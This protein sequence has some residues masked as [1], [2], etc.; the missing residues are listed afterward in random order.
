[1]GF[2]TT[3]RRPGTERERDL[4]QRV[5]D[6]EALIEEARR[7]ARRRRTVYAAI[8]I[9]AVAAG[10]VAEFNI[11]WSGA[12]T[13]TSAS[14]TSGALA[15]RNQPRWLPTNGPEG[16]AG[17]VAV[18]PAHPNVVYAGGGGSVFKSVDG[19]ASWH[20]LTA[21]PWTGVGAI[22]IDPSHPRVVYAGTD[23]GVAKSL[24]GGRSWRM[25]NRGLLDR[26]HRHQL[27][28]AAS[29]VVDASHPQTVYAVAAGTLFR[30]N[31]GGA[32]WQVI[33]PPQYRSHMCDHCGPLAYDSWVTPALGSSHIYASWQ[34]RR[35]TGLYESTDRGTTW[36]HIG[37]P[38]SFRPSSFQA[39]VF[40][41]T[42]LYASGTSMPGV[43]KSGDGGTTWSFAGLPR[44]TVW[45][46]GVEGGTLY[47]GTSTGLSE[48]GDGGATWRPVGTG[49]NVPTGAVVTDPR[50]PKTVYGTDENGVVKSVDG[51]RTWAA[52]DH[53]LVATWISALAL[54]PGK[55]LYAGTDRVFKST[56]GGATWR[57]ETGPLKWRVL[58]LAVSA[59]TVY[60]GSRGLGL[61]KSTDAGLTWEQANRGLYGTDVEAVAVDARVPGTVY[62][63][64]STDIA[65]ATA[66]GGDI[67]KSVDGGASWRTIARR[68]RL[69]TLAVAPQTGAVFGGTSHG[70]FRSTDGGESWRRLTPVFAPKP[71]RLERKR[72]GLWARLYPDTITAIAIDPRHAQTMYVG[73]QTGG[74][75][76]STDGG[77][78]WHGANAGL[79]D[80]R[81]VTLAIDPKNP[82]NLYAE[83]RS[84]VF[85]STDGARSWHRFGRDLPATGATTLAIDASGRTMYAG[86][87]G[88]G[89]I[90]IDVGR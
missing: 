53:G 81:I 20:R 70:L 30:T 16:G 36:R 39:L 2:T 9:A 89:V 54:G 26:I 45:E 78:T 82:Q 57:T 51:G 22:A 33:G 90:D 41:G 67:C 25:V 68:P 1:V 66:A 13:G 31:D 73:I 56:D 12:S 61:F 44:Q 55:T 64:C 42:S 6:L 76:A 65:Y 43:Y 8:V 38:G 83:T 58:S 50:E 5:S 21:K 23:Y 62:A 72:W 4:E 34:G 28:E 27:S 32:Q 52:S 85:Q 79:T 74:V 63:I 59:N 35:G 71:T 48:T 77:D 7:R 24:D 17:T 80:P 84:G 86:T 3:P 18:D 88:D 15:Q 69:L 14:G 37:L 75:V 47:A 87:G 11:G 19:G 29:V 49:T 10:L 40:D 60:A 46:L